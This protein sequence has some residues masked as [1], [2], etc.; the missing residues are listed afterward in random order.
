MRPEARYPGGFEQLAKPDAAHQLWGGSC[1]QPVL[2]LFANPLNTRILRAHAAG[3]QRLAELHGKIGCPAQTTLRAAL[4]NLAR[5]GR[6]K[7]AAGAPL[8][9]RNRAEPAGEE[10]LFV[11]RLRAGWR[12]GPTA[13]S[14]S[15]ANRRKASSKRWPVAGARP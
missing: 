3:P 14:L 4:A 12:A 7:A 1:R 6:W 11:A 13:R 9:G 5:S 10:M 15:T 8:R 2:S